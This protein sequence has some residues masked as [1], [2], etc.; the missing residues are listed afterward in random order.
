MGITD[1][2]FSMLNKKREYDHPPKPSKACFTWW[3]CSFSRIPS[4]ISGLLHTLK[5]EK[6]YEV[7]PTESRIG[8]LQAH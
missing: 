6:F 3:L 8:L 2:H 4:Q 5:H 1:K 7:G